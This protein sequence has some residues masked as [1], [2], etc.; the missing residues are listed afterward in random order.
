[1]RC[2]AFSL[3]ILLACAATR[4]HAQCQTQ[5]VAVF[6]L[7]NDGRPLI[8]VV[9]E[10]HTAL[11][12]VDTGA[13]G[14]LITVQAAQLLHLPVDPRR[15]TMMTTLAG[16]EARPNVVLN[17]LSAG[18]LE[19]GR[20]SLPATDM[21]GAGTAAGQ[22]IAGAIGMDLFG[23]FDIE[24]NLAARRMALYPPATC[25][26]AE[27]PWPRGTYETLE[28]APTPRHRILVP[29]VLDG[30][31][32][33]AVLDTGADGEVITRSAAESMGLGTIQ[34]DN[35]RVTHGIAADAKVFTQRN[36]HFASFSVGSEVYRDLDFPVADF[37]E[38]GADMLLGVNWM[39][40][41][42]LFVSG[43]SHRLFV[44]RNDNPPA[45][46]QQIAAAPTP[47]NRVG[48]AHCAAPLNVLPIL[49]REPLQAISRPRLPVPPVVQTQLAEGCAGATFRVA[50]DGSVHDVQVLTEWPTG[51]GL[52]DYVRHE[53]E[54]TRFQPPAEGMQ[55]LHYESH[56]LHPK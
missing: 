33:T 54:A 47:P 1:M 56:S 16:A 49:S 12:M 42:R 8:P 4:S 20:Q 13:E 14:T 40:L 25:T 43:A 2:L 34:I 37:Q 44:Q 51:Y 19:F 10:G 46:P 45:P 41:H 29:V 55:A 11:M 22:L 31:H 28:V 23:G 53:L 26:P 38:G 27:P 6:P 17:H 21:G 35:A 30:R 9:L 7:L 5:P 24:L 39:R 32:L 3:L 18:G 15:G 48:P 36:M 52:G 50:D